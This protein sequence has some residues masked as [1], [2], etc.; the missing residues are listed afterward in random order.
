LPNQKA[1]AVLASVANEEREHLGAFYALLKELEPA[2]EKYYREGEEEV[3]EM[4]KKL[5]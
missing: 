5:E 2:E 3:R 4:F 1:R